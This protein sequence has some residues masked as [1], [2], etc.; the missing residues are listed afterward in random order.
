MIRGQNPWNTS[1]DVYFT[2][3]HLSAR[4]YSNNSPVEE[5]HWVSTGVQ[6]GKTGGGPDTKCSGNSTGPHLHFQIDRDDGNSEPQVSVAVAA[7]CP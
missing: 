1:E 2:Y 5:G 3:A 7:K 4:V 6:I